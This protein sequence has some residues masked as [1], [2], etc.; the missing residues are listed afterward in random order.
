MLPA[1]FSLVIFQISS[2]TFC[3][4][5]LWTIVLLYHIAG[6][7]G[8]NNPAQFV[9]WDGLLLT[10]FHRLVSNCDPLNLCFPNVW[11]YK[12]ESSCLAPQLGFFSFF[13]PYKYWELSLQITHTFSIK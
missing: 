4:I 9:C 7:T 5:W 2:H 6:I 12:H 11:D 13:W 10:F 3:P 8:T 1:L